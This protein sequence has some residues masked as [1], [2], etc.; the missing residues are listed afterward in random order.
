MVTQM[1]SSPMI[2][3]WWW[4]R[5]TVANKIMK[6]IDFAKS[7]LLTLTYSHTIFNSK[8]WMWWID[9]IVIHLNEEFDLGET[10]SLVVDLVFRFA[11]EFD[12]KKK[13]IDFMHTLHVYEFQRFDTVFTNIYLFICTIDIHR[14]VHNAQNEK[15][16]DYRLTN[17][18]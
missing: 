12:S 6:S 10:I 1:S 5:Q 2:W 16:Y 17:E 7:I 8:V 4:Q 14:K 15:K 18:I 3:W 11:F 13:R 9:W